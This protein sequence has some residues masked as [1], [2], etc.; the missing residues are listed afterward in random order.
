MGIKNILKK[1]LPLPADKTRKV[2]SKLNVRLSDIET[3]EERLE[4]SL[5]LLHELNE[6][7]KAGLDSSLA[8]M[9]EV[10]NHTI[11]AQEGLNS[12]NYRMTVLSEREVDLAAASMKR[13]V[14]EHL[15]CHLTE[16]CNLNCRVC[17]VYA[18]LGEENYA[19]PRKFESD[20]A[21]LQ[22]FMGDEG[23]MRVHL[24]G[25]EPLLHPEIEKFVRIARKSFK[26]AEIDVTTNGLLVL[27]MPD[28]FW[29][30]LRECDVALKYTRYPVKFDYDKMVEYV[31]E[32][33]VSVFPAAEGEIEF[34]RRIPL[35]V[36]GQLDIYKSYVRCTYINC[37][38]LWDGRIYRCPVAA[39]SS[40]LN[41][42]MQKEGVGKEFHLSKKDYLDLEEDHTMQE[43]SDF[44][45]TA[46]PFCRYCDMDH[47]NPCL[48]WG[49]STKDVR[50]WVDL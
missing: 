36:G 26:Y 24:L 49:C 1:V 28:S 38:Q 46:T 11:A 41:R 9:R 20:T 43:I 3:T 15:D 10:L 7:H 33:G 47:V 4:G 21:N 50:E 12:L 22:K 40:R 30:T 16:H 14:I 39:F 34:F 18:P 31:A 19:D 48:P 6:G 35:D 2:I 8:E 29:D 45:S 27:G 25:G 13:N 23:V 44:L 5:A 37:V 32:K 17:S 42:A